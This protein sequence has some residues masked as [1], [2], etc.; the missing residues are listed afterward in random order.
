MDESRDCFEKIKILDLLASYTL[1]L[2]GRD[3]DG[4]AKCFTEDG[5]FSQG[6]KIIRGRDNLCAYAEVHG[7]TLGS[8][9]ITSSPCYRID[10]AGT[11]A[12]ARASTLVP[13]ATPSGYKIAMTGLYED[14]LKKVGDDWLIARRVVSVEGLPND[15]GFSM[16][17]ADPQVAALVQPLLDAWQRLSEETA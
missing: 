15:P 16:L 3:A 13:V 4:W 8:R 7:R 9:H 1:T 6:G 14:E 2:D 11:R 10:E 5:V 12:T 17:A